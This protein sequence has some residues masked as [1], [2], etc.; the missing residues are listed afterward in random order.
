MP[1]CTARYPRVSVPVPRTFHQKHSHQSLTATLQHHTPILM[2]P[3]RLKARTAVQQIGPTG[4]VEFGCKAVSC[5]APAEAATATA[6]TA[7][8]TSTAAGGA[9]TATAAEGAATAAAGATA[10]E[11][12]QQQLYELDVVRTGPGPQ[13]GQRVVVRARHVIAADGYFSR[14]RRTVRGRRVRGGV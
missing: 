9:V 2:K 10:D 5:A 7:A 11:Q 4:V 6:A 14:V 1:R 8:A 12:Q 3:Q 13:R